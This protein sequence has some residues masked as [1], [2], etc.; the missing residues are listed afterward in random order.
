M[1]FLGLQSLGKL[2]LKQVRIACLLFDSNTAIGRILL[3]VEEFW[4]FR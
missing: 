2:G 4:V 1:L 3:K